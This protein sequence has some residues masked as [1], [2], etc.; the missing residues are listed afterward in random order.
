MQRRLLFPSFPGAWGSSKALQAEQ[1]PGSSAAPN[2]SFTLGA[3]S[4]SFTIGSPPVSLDTRGLIDGRPANGVTRRSHPNPSPN[5]NPSPTPSPTPSPSP[6]PS[7]T[8]TL[9][10]L[11]MGDGDDEELDEAEARNAI[12]H[13][14]EGRLLPAGGTAEAEA[15]AEAWAAAAEAIKGT[16][17]AKEAAAEAAEAEAKEVEEA[18]EAKEAKE[19]GALLE[20]GPQLTLTPTPTPILPLTLNPNPTPNPNPIQGPQLTEYSLLRLWATAEC[21]ERWRGALQ[22]Q[23]QSQSQSQS[24]PQ[25]QSQSPPLSFATVALCARALRAHADA[26]AHVE[27]TPD[28]A[29]QRGLSGWLA[30]AGRS[31]RQPEACFGA[32]RGLRRASRPK[33]GRRL[34]RLAFDIAA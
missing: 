1:G 11:Q 7:L 30:E 4:V 2:L 18:K 13:Y 27:N 26:L 3:P 21:R 33:A 9:W 19:G 16:E 29:G 22:S 8:P 23:P 20:A 32:E 25:S 15:G 6:S 24:Q 34:S 17:E 14:A 31:L 5:S 28:R 10:H 12:Q